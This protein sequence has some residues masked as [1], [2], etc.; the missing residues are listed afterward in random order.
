MKSWVVG[1]AAVL[2]HQCKKKR[3]FLQSASRQLQLAEGVEAWRD[4][5]PPTSVGGGLEG[6]GAW[7]LGGLEGYRAPHVSAGRSNIGLRLATCAVR[8]CCRTRSLGSW[9]LGGCFRTGREY[10]V[11]VENRKLR[12]GETA[13]R[14]EPRPPKLVFFNGL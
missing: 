3:F 13:A 11:L 14:Q 12:T 10:N 5:E 6:L 1:L 2:P 7:R 4:G 9:V 8:R